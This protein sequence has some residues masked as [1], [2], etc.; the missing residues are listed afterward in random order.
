MGA[1]PKTTDSVEEA[2]SDLEQWLLAKAKQSEGHD[3]WAI[4]R[5]KDQKVIGNIMCKSLPNNEMEPSGEIE[6]GWHLGREYW[7]MGYATEAAKAVAEYGFRMNPEVP[8]FLAVVYPKNTASKKVATNIGMA[9]LGLSSKYY[10]A[11]LE[12][13]ELK[14]PE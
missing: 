5:K 8:R 14:R 9:P 6:I 3:E 12:V 7:G 10:G 1:T 4:I 13:F 2:K 11:E